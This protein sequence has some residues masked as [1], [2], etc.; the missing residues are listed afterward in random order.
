MS[1]A[2]TVSSSTESSEGESVEGSSQISEEQLKEDIGEGCQE[3]YS[4]Y[5]SP[6]N[7]NVFIVCAN[8]V[9]HRF[10]CPDT[11]NYNEVRE[12]YPLKFHATQ[13]PGPKTRVCLYLRS[14]GA[15]RS[16]FKFTLGS[17]IKQT[18]TSRRCVRSGVL[19]ARC[20][21]SCEISHTYAYAKYAAH[22]FAE[23]DA[24]RLREQHRE[25]ECVAVIN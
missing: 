15:S 16:Q 18:H 13:F 23:R 9:P 6:K 5:R 19:H 11:L 24:P 21:R 17:C 3:P 1:E 4:R 20:T 25:R 7:C 12:I 14:L 2:T 8:S 10:E 22:V